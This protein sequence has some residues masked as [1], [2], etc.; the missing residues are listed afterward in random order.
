MVGNFVTNLISG[1]FLQLQDF[2][3]LAEPLSSA[4]QTLYR[5]I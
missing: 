2:I 3:T 5:L 4:Q 1:K